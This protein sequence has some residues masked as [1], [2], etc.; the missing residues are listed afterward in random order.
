[1]Q[2]AFLNSQVIRFGNSGDIEA[3]PSLINYEI[4]TEG[5]RTFTT[6]SIVHTFVNLA[7]VE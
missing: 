7:H 2:D 3:R 5:E 4:W 6:M 1:M